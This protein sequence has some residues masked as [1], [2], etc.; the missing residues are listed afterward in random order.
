[1]CMCSCCSV[2]IPAHVAVLIGQA[3]VHSCAHNAAQ[4]IPQLPKC[5]NMCCCN[6]CCTT[7]RHSCNR[8]HQLQVHLGCH[9]LLKQVSQTTSS[10]EYPFLQSGIQLLHAHL[11]ISKRRTACPTFDPC[12]RWTRTSHARACSRLIIAVRGTDETSQCTDS[13][14]CFTLQKGRAMRSFVAPSQCMY[15]QPFST[16]RSQSKHRA[17]VTKTCAYADAGA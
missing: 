2:L 12:C 15:I 14:S 4:Q 10:S 8:W 5:F 6:K 17:T 16:G 9:Q 3:V 1:M 11:A 7:K 13:P